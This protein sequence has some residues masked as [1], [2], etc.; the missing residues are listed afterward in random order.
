MPQVM[1]PQVLNTELSLARCIAAESVLTLTP[2][3][4]DF[5]PQDLVLSGF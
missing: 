1:K 2:N 5:C 4:G 3:H